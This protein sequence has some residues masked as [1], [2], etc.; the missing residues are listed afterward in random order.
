M[1][2]RSIFR[3]PQLDIGVIVSNLAQVAVILP[4][5]VALGALFGAVL[6]VSL[7][8]ANLLPAGADPTLQSLVVALELA[9]RNALFIAA[10]AAGSAVPVLVD[11]IGRV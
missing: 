11:L 5:F 9:M 3:I 4:T 8:M 6:L 10:F 1:M 7:S 2:S